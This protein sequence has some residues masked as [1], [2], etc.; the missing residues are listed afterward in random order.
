LAFGTV[1]PIYFDLILSHRGYEFTPKAADERIYLSTDG[2][3]WITGW[4]MGPLYDQNWNP[5]WITPPGYPFPHGADVLFFGG[6]PD[7]SH[8]TV[9][10]WAD[11]PCV[12]CT[13]FYLSGGWTITESPAAVPEPG[14]LVL[15]STGL[16]FVLRKAATAKRRERNTL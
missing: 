3:G 12:E 16:L 14:T 5:Y 7:S 8:V 1:T 2:T 9:L 13:N 4:S 6:T 10:D 11:D 15:F